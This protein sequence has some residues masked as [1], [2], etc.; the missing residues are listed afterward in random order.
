MAMFVFDAI[1]QAAASHCFKAC[2]VYEHEGM[3]L[4]VCAELQLD[5]STVTRRFNACPSPSR[6]A[7]LPSKY[8]KLVRSGIIGGMSTF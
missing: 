7:L 5:N 3:S 6:I 1:S 4:C 8:V 2:A